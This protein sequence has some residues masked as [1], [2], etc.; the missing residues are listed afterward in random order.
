MRFIN[1][2]RSIS[3]SQVANRVIFLRLQE[4]IFIGLTV[5]DHLEPGLLFLELCSALQEIVLG[6]VIALIKVYLVGLFE[7]LAA[8]ARLEVFLG[9]I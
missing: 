8:H 5:L 7:L 6:H 2:L 9:I 4:V 1:S 3:I